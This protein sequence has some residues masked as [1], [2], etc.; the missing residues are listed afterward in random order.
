MRVKL[1]SR[2]SSHKHRFAGSR[3]VG[4]PEK[5]VDVYGLQGV[6]GLQASETKVKMADSKA[7]WCLVVGQ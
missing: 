6:T 3:P 2:L 4:G 5:G 7:V 1:S